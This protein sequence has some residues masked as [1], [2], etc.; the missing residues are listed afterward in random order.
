MSSPSSPVS[1]L[2]QCA[3][4]TSGPTISGR[5]N[6]TYTHEPELEELQALPFKVFWCEV[7]LVCHVRDRKHL[8]WLHSAVVGGLVVPSGRELGY[9]PSMVEF[10]ELQYDSSNAGILF[11]SYILNKAMCELDRFNCLG[12]KPQDITNEQHVMRCAR[13]CVRLHYTATLPELL[14]NAQS[15]RP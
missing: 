4:L 9:T 8:A 6:H 10:N 1:G 5:D 11:S 15:F 13:N 12:L 2:T 7:D 14:S 3:F